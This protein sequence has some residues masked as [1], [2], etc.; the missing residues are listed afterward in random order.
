MFR[1][2]KNVYVNSC[3]NML[4]KKSKTKAKLKI[5][6]KNLKMYTYLEFKMKRACD[7]C[8]LVIVGCRAK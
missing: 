3:S 7:L 2:I 4:I 8:F 5:R 1:Q 6:I